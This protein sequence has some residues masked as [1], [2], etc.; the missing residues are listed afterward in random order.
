MPAGRPTRKIPKTIKAIKD[1]LELGLTIKGACGCARINPDTFYLWQKEDPE[2]SDMVKEAKAQGQSLVE[3]AILT[4]IKKDPK[5]A[6]E[7]ARRRYEEWQ[8]RQKTE[9]KG[10]IVTTQ[11]L[12][13]LEI[14]DLLRGM[15]LSKKTIDKIRDRYL[16]A[17]VPE[18]KEVG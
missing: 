17:V 6:L 5:R 2:F 18:G 9:I 12:P 10:D 16:D 14:A 3:K 7:V 13:V 11:A 15:G 8:D 1:A 4:G